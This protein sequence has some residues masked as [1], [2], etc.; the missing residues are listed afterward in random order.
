MRFIVKGKSKWYPLE[1][2]IE[3][4]IVNRLLPCKWIPLQNERRLTTP[5]I[6]ITRTKWLPDE[7]SD[8]DR[9]YRSLKEEVVDKK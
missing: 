2:K 9:K 8:I 1:M 4:L 5:V 3:V 6:I 7:Y